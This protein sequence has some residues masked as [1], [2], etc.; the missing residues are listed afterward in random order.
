M[1]KEIIPHLTLVMLLT[2]IACYNGWATNFRHIRRT[3]FYENIWAIQYDKKMIVLAAIIVSCPL[4]LIA[5][6]LKDI[7]KQGY[8]K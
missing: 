8:K 1:N 6:F 4:W 7:V 5:S 2:W 3:K